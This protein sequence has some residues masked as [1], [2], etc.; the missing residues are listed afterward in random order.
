[1]NSF[2]LVDKQRALLPGV[3]V[4]FAAAAVSYEASRLIPGVSALLIAIILGILLTNVTTLPQSLAPGIDFAAKKLLR[5][6]IVFL[7]L[8]L[9][10]SDILALGAP[11]L[12]VVV[13]IVTGGIASTLLLGRLLRVRSQLSLLIACGFSICGAAAVAG[14]AGVTDPEDKKEE[15]TVTAVALVVIFGTLMI[16]LIPLLSTAFGLDPETAGKWAGG[17]IHEIAQV[18]A[19]GGIIGGSAL[20]TAVV[21]KL[22]RVLLLAPVALILSIHQRQQQ[23]AAAKSADPASNK[24]EAKLPPLVPPFIIGFLALVA[25]RSLL[26]VPEFVLDLGQFAQT[27]LLAAA[28]FGLGCGVKIRSRI[29]VGLRPFILAAQATLVV[30]T[31]SF[32]GMTTLAA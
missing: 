28:M 17:S 16:P 24:P 32:I 1:M 30:A 14:V 21:I 2:R 27:W 15:D 18:V 22:A 8:Q 11:T 6:G 7:G 12:L 23:R 10:L 9:V 5:L 3:A 20:S 4:S 13:C 31:I 26:P 29:T 19:V 25:L